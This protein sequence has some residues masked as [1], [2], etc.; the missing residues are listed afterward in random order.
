[1]HKYNET[2]LKIHMNDSMTKKWQPIGLFGF[3]ENQQR[4]KKKPN[5]ESV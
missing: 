2:I 5:N 4:T 3:R 1:M